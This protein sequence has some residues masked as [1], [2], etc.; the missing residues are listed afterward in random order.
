MREKKQYFLNVVAALLIGLCVYI[1]FRPDTYIS[2]LFSKRIDF[3]WLQNSLPKIPSLLTQF[4]RNYLCDIL[5]AYALFNAF[6]LIYKEEQAMGVFG[7]CAVFEIVV[8]VLQ[9]FDII[10]GT[11]DVVDIVFEIVATLTSALYI[12]NKSKRRKTE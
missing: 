12:K 6:F 4:A 3:T 7:I 9:L 8:E 5:W 2:V 10:Q 1:I 11:F